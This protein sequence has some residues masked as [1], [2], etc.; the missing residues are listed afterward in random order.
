MRRR[1]WTLECAGSTPIGHM[2]VDPWGYQRSVAAGSPVAA[3]D[4]HAGSDQGWSRTRRA[5]NDA[6]TRRQTRSVPE[7]GAAGGG[8]W[9]RD[10]ATGM[11]VSYRH[12]EAR[13]TLLS[14]NVWF[15]AY[16][17][18]TVRCRAAGVGRSAVRPAL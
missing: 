7:R 16:V 9:C 12:S 5:S 3:E 8:R 11:L 18:T 1:L 6:E 13:T 15:V 10:F 2:G 4:E 17:G 14:C